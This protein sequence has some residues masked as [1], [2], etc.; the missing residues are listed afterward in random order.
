VQIVAPDGT[1]K[2][3][4][5]KPDPTRAGAFIG[6]FPALLEGT[7]RQELPVPESEN[8]RLGRRIQVK[9]P[10]LER[11]NS[12]RNDPLLSSM[13]KETGGR[14]YIGL[15]QA[16]AASGVPP[17]TMQ[18]KDRTNTVVIPVAPNPQK[19]EQWLRWIM[20][21][22]FGLLCLEWLIRRLLRLA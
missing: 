8:E 4:A 22:L 21:G 7:Y 3:L 6:Q 2:T 11:D 13:A 5:L 16:L 20:L 10:D 19:E 17:L 14:Y 18:L 9:A 1:V 15:N 12:R